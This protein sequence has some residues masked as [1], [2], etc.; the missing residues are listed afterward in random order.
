MIAK[1]WVKV[2]EPKKQ[3]RFP[4]NKGDAGKPTWWPA[5]VRHKE[6]DHLM[7]PERHALLLAILRS[8]Q[9]RIARLQLATAEVIA[10]IKAGKVTYLMDVYRVAR[11][12]ERLRDEGLDPN[13]PITVSVSSLEGWDAANGC[14]SRTAVGLSLIHI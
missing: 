11:E 3:T 10:L 7:K 9:T 13:S 6:P 4:Y 12:E 8:P 1:E 5:D 2:I 14:A